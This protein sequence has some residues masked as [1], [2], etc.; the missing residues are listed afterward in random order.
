MLDSARAYPHNY[1]MSSPNTPE[2]YRSGFIAVAGRPN[3]GKST[4]INAYLGQ[5]IAAVSPKPQTTRRKQLGILTLPEAQLIFVDTPGIHKPIHKLGQH[6]NSKA[7]ELLLDADVLLVMF[8]LRLP[9]Q[10]DDLRVAE[11]IRSLDNAPPTIAALNKV[12]LIAPED[13][14]ERL[15]SFEAILPGVDMLPVSA[16][17]GD[18]R[19]LLLQRLLEY[20][21]KGP[22]YYPEQEITDFFERDIAGDLIRAAAL[23]LLRNEVPHAI[24][25]RV[26]EYKE[27]N[28]H[29]AYI[30]ATLFV[31]RDSQKGIVIGKGG[32]KLKEIGKLAR[33]HIEF[34]SGRKIFLRLRVKVQKGWRNDDKALKRF[35]FD[36]NE[37]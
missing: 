17:R 2:N 9:P 10:E 13:L 18:N 22:Q 36:L 5:T 24:A 35:G 29:G 33:Q 34:M 16:T 21:P 15:S 23:E 12:D 26:D 30:E 25:V 6:M 19:D 37:T 20:L 32:A 28:E 8:S 11:K 3:V 7:E 14:P 4:L 1:D 27:R 31:E